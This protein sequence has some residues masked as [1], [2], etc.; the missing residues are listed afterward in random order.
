MAR[1][2]FKAESKKLLDL[3]INSIYTNKEIFLREL[4]SNASDAIDKLFYRSLTDKHV[5][6]DRDEFEIKIDIDKENRLL[7]ITD[8]GIGMTVEELEKNL[9]TIAHSDSFDFKNENNDK[10]D[11]NIIGQ[12]GVG[13]YSS[14]MV[15]DQISVITKA[16]DSDTAY[17]WESS[18]ADGYSIQKSKKDIHGT[19]VTLKI[20]EDTEEGKY[21]D[22]LDSFHIEQLVRK[23][24][25][26]IGY[27][28]KMEIETSHLKDGSKD[29]YE[30]E[31]SLEILNSMIP[32][33]K[34]DKK[35]I[36]EEDYQQLY[37]DKFFDLEDALHCIHTS[38]EGQCSY[39][40]LL[41]IPSHAPYDFYTKEY[42]KGLE[43][44]SNGVLIMQKCS[45]L[46][47]DYFSFVK[48]LIDSSD[49]SLNI[50][51]ELLQ[52]DHQ[53]KLIEKNIEKKIKKE[54]EDMLE[55]ER[56]K[57]E[58]FFTAFGMQLK[59][60]IYNNYGMNKDI[61]KDLILFHSYKQDK[62]ITLKEYMESVSEGQDKIYYACGESTEKINL[63]PQVEKVKELGYDILYLT[64]YVDEFVIQILM[65]YDGKNFVNVCA[66]DLEFDSD[67]DKGKIK[68]ANETNKDLLATMKAKLNTTVEDVRF[69][70]RL[71]NHPVC[72]TTEGPVSTEMEKVLGAMPTDEK[73]KAKAILEINDNHPI[74]DKLKKLSNNQEELEKYAEILYAQARLIEGLSIDNP[75]EI[76]SLI[77][78]IIAK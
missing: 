46:L 31:V 64:E 23:Y 16:F 26:Y 61:L 74:A 12:F 40:A 56:E 70:N 28:I 54:L 76:S 49:L 44:Y 11:I 33:W 58:K 66:G 73:I 45:D 14:F 30:K 38:V 65:E 10:D 57:Y 67:E 62:M 4:I 36:T 1:K 8:N 63:L 37:H 41:F 15:S 20:K 60:G 78:D 9:G 77:C 39:H 3:M 13:F 2:Q 21:S 43:L 27:P 42:E 7:T 24:S 18:G 48:G 35:D 6:I 59:F 68:A 53:L 19:S 34:K 5:K 71:K 50:S 22:Y 17:S 47:P 32:L 69:T 52:H 55:N 29:E 75:T 72:L 25:D 51:R